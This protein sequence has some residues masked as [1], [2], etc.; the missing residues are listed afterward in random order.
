MLDYHL[1]LKTYRKYSANALRA[2]CANS[3]QPSVNQRS[4]VNQLGGAGTAG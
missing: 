1:R 3:H 2:R 4:V